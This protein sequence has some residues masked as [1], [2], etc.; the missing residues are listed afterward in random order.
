MRTIIMAAGSAKR[1]LPLTKDIPKTLL[2][3]GEKTILDH[4]LD[5][6]REAGLDHFDIVTG[7]GHP[8]IEEFATEYQKKYP[9]ININLIYN[10]KF[11]AAG[12]IVSM[13]CAHEVFD[14]DFILI[15]SDTIFHADILRRL[16]ESEYGN[17][18]V[19]D[20]VKELGDEEMKV[21]TNEEESIAHIHK[22]LSPDESHG[23]YIGVMKLTKDIKDQLLDAL[24]KTISD[25][26]SLYYEDGIQRMIEDHGVV[27][28]PLSTNGM[29]CMEIDTHEDLKRANSLINDF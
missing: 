1:L 12:N 5:T 4:I 3:I 28:K 9:D 19:V 24:D 15:N 18:M 6:A 14:E 26:D 17:A 20:D 11:D 2:R 23:E 16:I 21:I 7:H 8:A 27:V 22:S 10:D 29:P 25:D 13:R